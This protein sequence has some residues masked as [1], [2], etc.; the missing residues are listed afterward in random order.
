MRKGWQEIILFSFLFKWICSDY[1][2]CKDSIEDKV[3]GLDF[4]A[5]DYL[6]KP[7]HLVE[8]SARIKSVIRRKQF[9]ETK[10]IIVNDIIKKILDDFIDI[11]HYKGVNIEMI[12]MTL[13]LLFFSIT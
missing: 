13:L 10:E 6:A 12:G 8:L 7:F 2:N 5:D 9:P 3:T 1:T 11:Y 4:G